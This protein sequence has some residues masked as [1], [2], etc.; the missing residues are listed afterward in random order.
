M[1]ATKNHIVIIYQS[2]L[3]YLS[4]YTLDYPNIETGGHLFGFWKDDGTP[5]V[6]FVLGPGDKSEHSFFCFSP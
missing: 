5:V 6:T 3:E 2:E 1:N 4:R